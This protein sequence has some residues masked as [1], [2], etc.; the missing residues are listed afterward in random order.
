MS[1]AGKPASNLSRAYTDLKAGRFQ[2]ECQSGNDPGDDE[3]RYAGLEENDAEKLG[4]W[5]HCWLNRACG[6]DE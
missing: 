2:K 6:E 4:H 3:D 1:W 5:A